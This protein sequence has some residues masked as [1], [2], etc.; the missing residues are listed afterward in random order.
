MNNLQ[1]PDFISPLFGDLLFGIVYGI[2]PKQVLEHPRWLMICPAT[3]SGLASDLKP[4]PRATLFCDSLSLQILLLSEW[5]LPGFSKQTLTRTSQPL[6]DVPFSLPSHILPAPY[7]QKSLPTL[8]FN[9]NWFPLF[10]STLRLS[11]FGQGYCLVISES[12]HPA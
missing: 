5:L 12:P 1:T 8:H 2:N 3:R 9:V 11:F 6:L 7:G 4:P 10:I